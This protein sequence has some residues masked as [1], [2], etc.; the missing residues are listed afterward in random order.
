MNFG[1]LLNE[2]RG[3]GDPPPDGIYDT[4]CTKAEAKAAGTGKPMI[5]AAFRVLTGPEA[6]KTITNNFVLSTENPNAFWFFVRHMAVFGIDQATLTNIPTSVEG[7]AQIAPHL[8]GKQARLTIQKQPGRNLPNVNQVEP[9]P[10]GMLSASPQVQPQIN[11]GP[12]PQVVPQ[13]LV[14]QYPQVSPPSVP[15]VAPPGYNEVTTPAPA[16]QV[17]TPTP[18]YDQYGIVPPQVPS[19]ATIQPGEVVLPPQVQEQIHAGFQPP[20]APAPQDPGPSTTPPQPQEGAPQ[21]PQVPF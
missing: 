13:V 9:V 20:P 17:S 21:P 12:S 1:Q 14:D 15:Q 4:V 10:G 19:T 6:N 18:G 2:Y 8:V 5:V 11:G 16:P 7:L 3:A